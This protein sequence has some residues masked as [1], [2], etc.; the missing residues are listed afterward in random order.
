MGKNDT[1]EH[2]V[3]QFNGL[4]LLVL[5]GEEEGGPTTLITPSAFQNFES[6]ESYLLKDGV[7]YQAGEYVGSEAEIQRDGMFITLE[8]TERGFMRETAYSMLGEL[9]LMLMELQTEDEQKNNLSN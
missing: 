7:I 2:E 5:E 6:E 3:V 1:W 9:G 4:D 8:P